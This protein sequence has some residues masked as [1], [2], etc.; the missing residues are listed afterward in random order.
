MASR[1][2]N[3]ARMRRIVSLMV[4]GSA[5]LAIGSRLDAAPYYTAI[6]LGNDPSF[7]TDSNQ[8]MK[9]VTDTQTGLTYPFATTT[10]PITSADLQNLPG[11]TVLQGATYRQEIPYTMSPTAINGSGTVI[12]S[13]PA[14]SGYSDP[15][16]SQTLG[17]A[18]RQADGRYSPF[19]ALLPADPQ[20]GTAGAL[21]LSQSNQILIFDN[22]NLTSSLFDVKTGTT[23]PISQLIP[24]ALLQQLTTSASNVSLGYEA[25]GIDDRGDI[26]VRIYGPG[27]TQGEE[28]LLTP[29]GL[30]Q[31]VPSPEP[32]TLLFFG[33]VAGALGV[34]SMLHRAGRYPGE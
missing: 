16:V 33:L 9:G 34:R 25:D 31:P 20:V 23:T 21:Y 18:V 7:H 11:G 3:R 29:P 26:L 19:V 5:W 15:W 13:I 4:S 12:G 22:P 24:P 28:F 8:I 10:T 32:S 2:S 6:P 14:A 17:Y 1:S 30:T 27:S